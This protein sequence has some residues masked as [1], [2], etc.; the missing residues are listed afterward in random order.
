ML[1]PQQHKLQ[2]IFVFGFSA[3]ISGLVFSVN[4]MRTEIVYLKENVLFLWVNDVND[5]IYKLKYFWY[6]WCNCD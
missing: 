5:L 6:L 3:T 2:Y 4:R 1:S